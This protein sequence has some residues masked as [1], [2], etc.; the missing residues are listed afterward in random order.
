MLATFPWAA[1]LQDHDLLF[2]VV[3]FI[4]L[5]SVV[6]QGTTI[7]PLAKLL[8]LDKPLKIHPKIP[9]EFENTGNL[10]GETREFEIL[11]GS[12]FI[13]MRLAELGL[14]KGALVLLIRREGGFIIPHGNVQILENDSLMVLGTEQILSEAGKVLGVAEEE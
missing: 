7:M 8:K 10:D 13:G 3:F 11:T 2:H 6:L 14:P 9:L 1:N 5:T 4:V 12:K